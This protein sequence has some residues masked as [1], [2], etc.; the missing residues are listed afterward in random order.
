MKDQNQHPTLALLLYP[1]AAWNGLSKP[2]KTHSRVICSQNWYTQRATELS[3]HC[4]KYNICIYPSRKCADIRSTNA[5]IDDSSFTFASVTSVPVSS[6]DVTN[7]TYVDTQINSCLPLT[8]GVM[9]G[10]IGNLRT[11][12]SLILLL[13]WFQIA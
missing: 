11:S 3:R 1:T 12:D 7:K 6:S 10:A 2:N 4:T 9:T 13:V 5:T 8:G